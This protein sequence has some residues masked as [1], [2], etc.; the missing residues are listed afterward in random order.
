VTHT[1]GKVRLKFAVGK[2]G[3]GKTPL[4]GASTYVSSGIMLLRSQ[5]IHFDGLRLEDVVFIDEDTD[6][7]MASTRV[8]PDDILLNITG[9]S[10]GRCTIVPKDI[11]PANV[12]QH[13][14]IIRPNKKRVEPCFLNMA[15]QSATVQRAIFAGENGSSREGLTFEQ[16]GNFEIVLP[17]LSDQQAIADYLARETARLDTLV[18]A[19]ERLLGLL[20]EKR[21][22]LITHAVTRGLDPYAPIHDSGIPW[23]GEIPAHWELIPL[24]FLVDI[25]GGATPD[26]G[27]AELWD[28]DIPWVS[29]KDMKRDEIE[30]AEDHVSALALSSSAVRLIDPMAVLIVV[31]GMILAHSFPT[32]VT[33]QPVT[34]NQDM[35]A[36]RCRELLE[37]RYLRDYLR[38]QEVQLVSIAEESAHGTRKLESEVLGRFPV[39]VP[40]MKEQRAIVAHIAAETGKLDALHAATER[41]IALLKER[42]AALIAAAVTGN[43][44]C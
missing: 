19:K 31:R 10:L 33:T 2:I 18:A 38:G 3:S 17:P 22:A 11:S 23:L 21:R 39:C 30:D 28:G 27:K 1:W 16:I 5:N 40:P 7:Q 6:S 14:C 36:L 4:G 34:I 13:V 42:R 35:K 20:A 37:P 24:R 41:T 15:L 8:Q 9:A 43:L 26:T 12:N 29:P 25:L 44:M 32:A